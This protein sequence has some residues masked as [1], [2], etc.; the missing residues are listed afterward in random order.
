MLIAICTNPQIR[1]NT[2][3]KAK[4]KESEARRDGALDPLLFVERM[5]MKLKRKRWEGW[6]VGLS[7]EEALV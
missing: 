2:N 6:C 7:L 5:P 4:A 1:G 3:A